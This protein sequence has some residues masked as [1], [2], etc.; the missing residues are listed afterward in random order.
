LVVVQAV[1]ERGDSGLRLVKLEFQEA[2]LDPCFLKFGVAG[3]E[4]A[5]EG[6]RAFPSREELASVVRSCYGTGGANAACGA[7]VVVAGVHAARM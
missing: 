3:V 4:I 5:L 2:N 1:K 7:R 6:C